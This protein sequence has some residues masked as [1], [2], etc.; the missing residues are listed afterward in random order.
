MTELVDLSA[1]LLHAA[2]YFADNPNQPT[3]HQYSFTIVQE[4]D[5]ST[6]HTNRLWRVA[7]EMF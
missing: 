6:S 4:V 1:L 2:Q 5:L 3:N 7:C